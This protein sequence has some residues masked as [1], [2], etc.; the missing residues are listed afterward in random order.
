M[1]SDEANIHFLLH[2]AVLVRELV[3]KELK[4]LGLGHSQARVLDALDRMGPSSQVRLADVLDVTAASMSAMSTRMISNGHLERRQDPDE[5]RSNILS[6][7]ESGVMLLADVRAA[8]HRVDD[9]I[10]ARVGTELASTLFAANR[11]LRDA[12]GGQTPGE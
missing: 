6:L 9:A 7:S 2:S 1:G 3:Q 5:K 4:P 11:E 12:L 10:R 8:W